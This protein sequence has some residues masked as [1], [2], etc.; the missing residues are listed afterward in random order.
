MWFYV[1]TW[2]P[3]L[4]IALTAAVC[5]SVAS[6]IIGQT[7]PP[8]YAH[9]IHAKKFDSRLFLRK[10]KPFFLARTHNS[11]VVKDRA[12]PLGSWNGQIYRAG[13]SSHR[14]AVKGLS[15]SAD[16]PVA[17]ITGASRGIGAATAGE[18][19]RKG[20]RLVLAARSEPELREIAGK[21]DPTG[22]ICHIVPTDLLRKEDL[23]QLA[24]AALER[25]GRVDVL[26]HNAGVA[27]PGRWVADLTDE[28]V[29][30]VIGTNLLA[31]IALTRHLL[32]SMIERRSGLIVF[33]DSIG[34]YISLPTAAVYTATKFGLRGFAGSLRREVMEHGIKVSI[35]SPGFVSTRLTD[36]V[37]EAVKKLHLPM[38]SPERI[39]RIIVRTIERPRREIIFP[40]YYHVFAWFERNL[41]G[42]MDRVLSPVLPI[43]KERV[44]EPAGDGDV[45]RHPNLKSAKAPGLEI[46]PKG[47]ALADKV[48]EQRHH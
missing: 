20:Y 15:A 32:P 28:V 33:I 43:L 24:R 17:L 23:E 35:I 39:A 21:L 46:P 22:S 41:P 19:A 40:G 34:G 2:L 18:L 26:I 45:K 4:T 3:L 14:V 29:S 27:L 47:L 42:L 38:I 48:I 1:Q 11:V 7:R 37:S 9:G 25:F 8:A 44:A 5:F 6:F 36:E 13:R 12:P 10:G 30:K 16:A 31:P